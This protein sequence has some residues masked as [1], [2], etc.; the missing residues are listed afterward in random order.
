M[1]KLIV[2]LPEE[3]HLPNRLAI[4]PYTSRRCMMP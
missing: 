4:T 1:A 3:V 2:E